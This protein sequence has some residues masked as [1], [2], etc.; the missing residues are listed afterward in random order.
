MQNDW[1]IEKCGNFEITVK[2]NNNPTQQQQH[3]TKLP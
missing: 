1:K 3:T 2:M